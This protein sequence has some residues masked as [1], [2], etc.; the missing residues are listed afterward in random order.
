MQ[1]FTGAIPF[2]GNSSAVAMLAIVQGRRPQR[3]IYPTFTDNLWTLMQRCWDH[4]PH[5]RPE[6]SEVLQVLLAPLVFD[7]L[8][9]IHPLA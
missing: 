5:L 2:S 9:I 4:D 3:P 1:V 8:P 6:V 7:V